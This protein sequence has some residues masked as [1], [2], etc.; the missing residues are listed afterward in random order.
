MQPRETIGDGVAD[1]AHDTG[2]LRFDGVEQLGS[3]AGDA[4]LQV[5][6]CALDGTGAGGCLLGY[7]LRAEL[8]DGFV[9]LIGCDLP[10]GQGVAEVSGIGAVG[11]HGFLEFSGRAWDG[12]GELV[13]VLRGELSLTGGLG[14]DHADGLE[15]LRVAAG[16]R[17]EVT[18][19]LS[20]PVVPFNIV[21]CQL[22]GDRLDIR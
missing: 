4:G 6:P 13:P 22:G 14:E 16:D 15:S 20:E 11:S 7:V 1:A 17:I 18:G 5:A 12:V 9:E 8:H 10:V 19:G 2:D 3:H 21:R